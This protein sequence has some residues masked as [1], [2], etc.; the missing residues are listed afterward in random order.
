ML[1]KSPLTTDSVHQLAIAFVDDNDFASD[2]KKALAKMTKT[3]NKYAQLYE[4]TAGRVQF[5][6]THFLVGNG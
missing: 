5:D 4:A 6:K 1:I 3:L 2:G